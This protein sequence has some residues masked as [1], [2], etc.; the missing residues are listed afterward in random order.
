MTTY[1]I[2]EVDLETGETV[3]REL[4]RL[5]WLIFRYGLAE[6]ITLE[7]AEI[8]AAEREAAEPNE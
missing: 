8:V 3:E 6:D 7:A 2:H 5:Q 4:D 1:T